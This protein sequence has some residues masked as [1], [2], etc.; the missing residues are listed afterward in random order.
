MR[1]LTAQ[2]IAIATVIASAPLLAQ[3]AD[4]RR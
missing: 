1:T 4:P 2:L 3:P